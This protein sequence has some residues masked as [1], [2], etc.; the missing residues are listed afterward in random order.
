[1]AAPID[2][3]APNTSVR[4]PF[5]LDE[6][7]TITSY[8]LAG[9]WPAP[10]ARPLTS[11]SG[12]NGHRGLPGHSQGARQE[13]HEERLGPA[14]V[15]SP[16]HPGG[17]ALEG[18]GPELAL[19]F[20]SRSSSPRRAQPLAAVH[21]DSTIETGGFGQHRPVLGGGGVVT[22]IRRPTQGTRPQGG[23]EL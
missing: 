1:M 6:L 14:V 17:Q 2:P 4:F 21:T 19:R 5:K 12:A 9:A 23:N 18:A 15:D 16:V 11:V 10:V 7:T 22:G 13:G 3:P 8:F 20:P